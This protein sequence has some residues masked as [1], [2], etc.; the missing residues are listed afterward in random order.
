MESELFGHRRGA[1]TGATMDR[2]GLFAAADGGSLLLDEVG[3][4]P[5]Y[6][7]TKLLRVLQ[8]REYRPIGGD[9]QVRTDFRLISSTNIEIGRAV[10]EGRIREDL[11][12]RINTITLRVPPLRERPEDIPVLAEHFVERYSRRYDRPV[13]PISAEAYDVLLR[14][15]WPGNVRELENAIER[16]VLVSSGPVIGCEDLPESLASRPEEANAFRL[17]PGWTLA[18]LERAAILHTLDQARWNKQVAA[19]RLGLH[20]PTLYSKMKKHGIQRRSRGA[21]R[22]GAPGGQEA[23]GE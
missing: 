21:W 18:D 4:M 3:E 11:L 22:G 9:R 12:F 1:F 16:A 15:R 6:L 10:A 5:A 13:R 20:R 14:A 17:P 8:E 23:Q 2:G 7:Q 19:A